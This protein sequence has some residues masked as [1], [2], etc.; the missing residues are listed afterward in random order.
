[1]VREEREQSRPM[2]S[3]LL[4]GSIGYVLMLA[5]SV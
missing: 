2:A 5:A 4:K 3:R 1:M